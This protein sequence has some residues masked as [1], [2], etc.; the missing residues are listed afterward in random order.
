MPNE[1]VG[2]VREQLAARGADA[3]LV[4]NAVNRRYL[5][6]FTGTSG[7]LLIDGSRAALV[8]DFRYRE[9]AG[10]QAA[11]FAVVEH[12]PELYET[13]KRLLVEWGVSRLLFEDRDVTFAAYQDIRDKLNPAELIPAGEL[14]ETLRMV[15]D[16]R[17]LAVMREAADLADRAFEHIL[18]YIRPGATEASIALE[19]EFYMRRNGASGP[20]FDTIVASGERSAMP[21]GVASDRVIGKGEFV[22]LDFGAYYKGYCSDITRTVVVG[23]PSDK[24]R[25]IYAIVLE[26]QQAALDR[27]APGMTG[28]QGD[29][30][31]RDVI[32]R[33]GYGEYFGHG[34][35]HG[36]GM[37]I[38]EAP[39]L[40]RT[41]DTVL[42]PGMTVTV[43]PGIYL[44]GFGGVRIEDDVV[45]TDTGIEIL[46]RS[47]KEL[48]VLD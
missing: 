32:T 4:T 7:V 45:I 31:T 46:T 28:K 42:T 40:S 25:E 26:A 27:L 39:R 36:F 41:C 30:L 47:P 2:K 5:S 19:L 18:P 34:T 20:S 44:P 14:V 22:T 38:H 33:Y 17:E 10:K 11:G 8:T 15:K 23:K 35:G 21:H 43:E 12:G 3:L 29:A 9:Q 48:I 13:V 24:Q 6:G 37:E 1:R 16:E